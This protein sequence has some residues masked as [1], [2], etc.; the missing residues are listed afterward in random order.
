MVAEHCSVLHV[1]FT[2]RARVSVRVVFLLTDRQS[3]R[4]GFEP[5]FGTH[6]RIFASSDFW[7]C[8]SWGVLPDGGT[9]LSFN[10]SQSLSVS[11]VYSFVFKFFYPFFRCMFIHNYIGD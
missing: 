11:D 4:L 7:L 5:P 2:G 8:L 3:V 10:G 1:A 9:D 6:G